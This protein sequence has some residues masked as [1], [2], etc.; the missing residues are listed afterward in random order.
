M[1]PHPAV[2]AIR[3]AVRRVLHDIL[4]DQSR[5]SRTAGESTGGRIT[6]RL[7][8][9]HGDIPEQTPNERTPSP[10]VL[11]AWARGGPE[12][13]RTTPPPHANPHQTPHPHPP[14]HQPR[15]PHADA[16]RHAVHE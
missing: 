12:K 14:P 7:A 8:R 10:L 4:T 13:A 2:A 1:G 6:A 5:L 9:P 15:D 16:Q 11:V 3:L